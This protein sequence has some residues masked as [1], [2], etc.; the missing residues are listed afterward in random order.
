MVV[1]IDKRR[2]FATNAYAPIT[3]HI[4]SWQFAQDIQRIA[5]LRESAA[6]DIDAHSPTDHPARRAHTLYFHFA[7]Q[8]GLLLHS[9]D[10]GRKRRDDRIYFLISHF[11]RAQQ[12]AALCNRNGETAI[13]TTDGSAYP[14]AIC[15]IV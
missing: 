11:R 5:C 8:M 9:Q 2:A 10:E 7:Q 6:S 4:H 15:G 12:I 13:F 3:I 14:T 1:D